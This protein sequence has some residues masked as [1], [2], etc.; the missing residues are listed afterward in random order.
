MVQ[1]CGGFLRV[2][3][4]GSTADSQ[5]VNRGSTPR[6]R[7]MPMAIKRIRRPK[8]RT[9]KGLTAADKAATLVHLTDTVK[10]NVAHA[11]THVQMAKRSKNNPTSLKHNLEHADRHIKGA[12]EHAKKLQQKLASEKRFQPAIRQ[13]KQ[14]KA[15]GTA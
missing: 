9:P 1:S 13:L 7:T 6:T 8:R 2:S 12:Q 15:K 5:S 11:D 10:E 14:A 4:R 3:Y